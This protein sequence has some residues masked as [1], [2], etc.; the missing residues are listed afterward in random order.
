[1]FLYL[2]RCVFNT[3]LFD[4]KKDL[5]VYDIVL[6]ND[7]GLGITIM[8]IVDDPA[9][10]KNFMA[11]SKHQVHKFSLNEEERVITGVALRADFPIY[12]NDSHG[13]Y[14]VKFSAKTIKDAA[15]RFF[16]D[17]R[18]KDVNIDHSTEVT[19]VYLYE[20]YLLNTNHT[21][22]YPEFKDVANG[23]WIVSYKVDND[24]VWQD[25]KA[26][27]LNGFSVEINAEME[28]ENFDSQIYKLMNLYNYAEKKIARGITAC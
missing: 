25:I 15:R 4:M 10:E 17:M 3:L 21:I 23:S 11:F 8:S 5:P 18:V 13:E 22:S 24:N 27:K 9:V 7:S 20:S 14:Y 28:K 16:K 2:R 1:M 26:G 6:D 19:G 12:R